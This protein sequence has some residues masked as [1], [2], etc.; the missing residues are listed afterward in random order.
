MI[1][2]FFWA[3]YFKKFEP[4]IENYSSNLK[5]KAAIHTANWGTFSVGVW[6]NLIR[7][8][9][10][11]L[12]ST[13]YGAKYL[14]SDPVEDFTVHGSELNTLTCAPHMCVAV[15]WTLVRI[16]D[17]Q[18]IF[19]TTEPIAAGLAACFGLFAWNIPLGAGMSS[20]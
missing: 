15:L 6:L 17:R 1:M 11:A 13:S 9:W 5:I 2:P 7:D 14:Y 20:N 19:H 18:S 12:V 10:W 16:G 3:I 8:F 4:N